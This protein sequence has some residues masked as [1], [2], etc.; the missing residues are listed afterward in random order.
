VEDFIIRIY[1]RKEENGGL[2]GV[3]EKVGIE[4]KNAFRSMG[5]LVRLLGA[6]MLEERR[7]VESTHLAIPVTVEGRD[8]AGKPF[9]EETVIEDLSPRGAGFLLKAQV[10]EGSELQLRIVPAY[11]G[12]RRQARVAS[13]A[14][15]PEPRVVEVVFQ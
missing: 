4:G 13:I 9:S 1:R 3:V 5:E 12:L 14:R 7:K 10:L 11:C 2:F 15:G 6:E 8:I